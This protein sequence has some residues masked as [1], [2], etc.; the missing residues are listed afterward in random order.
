MKKWIIFAVALLALTLVTVAA[1][2]DGK[3]DI[4]VVNSPVEVK[5][6][7][8]TEDGNTRLGWQTQPDVLYDVYRAPSRYAS[9]QVIAAAEGSYTDTER[10]C[11]Y[12]VA[13]KNSE[14]KILG[15]SDVVSEEMTLFGDNVYIFAPTDNPAEV[16]NVIN[17]V[18]SKMETAHFTNDRYAFFFKSGAY[19][20]NISLRVPFFT[21][22][23]GLGVNQDDTTVGA[24]NCEGDWNHTSLVNF[25]RGVENLTFSNTSKWAVSQ[26]TYLR[27]VHV[28]GDL[29]LYDTDTKGDY[30][31]ASGG[32]LANSRVDGTVYSGSQQQW[33][34][35]NANI[36]SWQ[37]G[38][39]N[40]VFAGVKNAPQGSVY[41]SVNALPVLREKPYLVYE[42]GNYAIKVPALKY[43]SANYESNATAK[44][45]SFD[46][47]Y[48]ARAD[49]DNAATINA[50]IVS[51]KHIVF[52]PGVYELEAP[53]VV[54]RADTVLLGTG[55]ATLVSTKGN[56]CL[57]V[58]DVDGVS[59]S[60]LLFDAGTKATDTLVKV[61][62]SG[63]VHADNPT[64]LYDCFFRVGG[65]V[66]DNTYADIS[67]EINANN[68]V[69]DNI[70]LW[71][72]D[73]GDGVGWDSN[74]GDFGAVVN[75]DNVKCYGLFG[76]HYKKNNILWRGNGGYVVF[77]QSEIAY[78]V[79][80]N[81]RWAN[82]GT[83]G[84]A[85]FEVSEDVTQFTAFGMG[86]YSNFWVD[87][88]ELDSALRVPDA[89]G[90][91]L[92]YVCAFAMSRKGIVHN[93]INSD[94][95]FFDQSDINAGTHF[96]QIPFY[97]RF[98]STFTV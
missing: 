12:K 35:R 1:C 8:T 41:T 59:V 66:K 20:R 56:S 77:Y 17:S 90:I 32:F 10:Y 62:N 40:M 27:D 22:F 14:G 87:G 29:Y 63:G 48:F 68:C 4:P 94:G 71:R 92:T 83:K 36:G 76:E 6:T 19:D 60:G 73:H 84:F 79:P 28:K 31:T 80:S 2:D 57:E 91:R 37:G 26:G 50:N 15:I 72:A 24:I 67:L 82:G 9:Y 45:I 70:W 43:E 42:N 18:Y 44:T 34:T 69:T 89:S 88:I 49:R 81:E 74:N 96:R 75:G 98:E 52:L 25:W 86:I 93:V 61:G 95:L 23:A 7:L 13:A 47:I 51:G 58:G 38:V 21:T 30:L 5:L 16:R 85:S 55:L 64:F 53:I 33:F 39:W 97:G 11:Y 65:N 78:D 46:N 3:T 54:N